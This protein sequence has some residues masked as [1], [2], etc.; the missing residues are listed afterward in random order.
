MF[1][2]NEVP[3]ILAQIKPKIN[4]QEINNTFIINIIILN[5]I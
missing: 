1:C 3:S 5:E 2:I 4:T